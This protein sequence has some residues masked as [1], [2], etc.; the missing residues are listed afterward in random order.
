MLC[1]VKKYRRQTFDGTVIHQNEEV[2]AVKCKPG[3]T[4]TGMYG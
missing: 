2:V 1:I 3:A 4:V